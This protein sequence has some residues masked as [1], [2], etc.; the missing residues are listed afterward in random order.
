MARKSK[1]GVNKSQA[2]RDYINAN[3]K[4]KP[5]EIVEALAAQGVTVS[6]AFVST[7]RSN[8]KRKGRKGPGRRG[9]PAASAGG[10]GFGLESLVQAKKLADKMGGVSKAREALDALAKILAE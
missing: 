6:P 7:L 1:S 8:D 10:G 4:S 2:I 5:K 3:P 9:R